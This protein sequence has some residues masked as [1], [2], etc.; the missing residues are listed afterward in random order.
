MLTS[1]ARAHLPQRPLWLC[2]TCAHPWPC[3]RAKLALT[4]SY[5]R[6]PVG[7]AV[8]LCAQ[9]HEAVADL[10]AISPL[11]TPDSG[12]LFT[13]FIGWTRPGSRRMP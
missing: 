7:L 5:A 3:G 11:E 9:L 4:R 12:T 6:N 1:S 8:Y 10:Y 2:R 13:R